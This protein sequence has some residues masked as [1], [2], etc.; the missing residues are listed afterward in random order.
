M[1]MSSV[2]D[3]FAKN[4]NLKVNGALSVENS[5]FKGVPSGYGLF[6]DLASINYDPNDVTIELLRIPR[7]A[8]FSLDTLLELIKDETQYSSKENMEKLH[9]TVRAVFSQFL[10][11]DGLKSLLSETTVLVF[12]FTLLTLVKE[13][14]EL[15][16]TLR[17]YLEDV[18]LQVKVDNAPMFCEQAAELYGQ[19]SM[20]V[21]L[22]DVLD[23][24]EDFFKNKV[25]CSRSVLPLLRQVYAAIS[26]RSL[27]IPDEVA[28]NSDDFVVNTTLVPLLDFANHSNDLKNAHFD[29]DRQTRDVLLLLDVD[30]IPA[31]A[32]KFEIFISYSPVED[33]ISFIHY[34]GFVPSSADKCQFI[35]LSFDRGYLREQE[36]MPAVNLR[37]FYKWM[38]INPVVQ[39]INFQNCWHINDSTEQFAYLLLAFMHSPDSESSSCWAYDPTCYRTFWYFQEHSSKR[40]EDYISINDYKSRIA[41]LENDDSD[42]IDLPQLAWSMSFQGD[43]LSTHRGRFPKD[44][45]LQL[46]PFDNE[47]TFS[48]A[49][50]LFAKFFLGYIE[51]RLDKLENSEPHLTSPPLKQLVRLEKS[52]LLQLLHEPHLYYWSDRQVDCESYD[53]T[54]RPLLDR[55]HRDADR[56]ASKDV[57]SLENLSLEDY[58]PEDFTDFLQDELKLYANLV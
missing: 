23:L 8:T 1:S 37:L 3:W 4:A 40:K 21:A 12:Y 44:E 9:A 57:L 19:Y 55:G 10:E 17:F 46:A 26:S 20:F 54:L 16:K 41:S 31:N 36:P 42:L 51:W 7:L 25:S 24:L 22:K 52:V 39:L 33:L 28:E 48:N 30:R 45:A 6:V 14:Y 58:H 47:R 34:Y 5:F 35:S 2:V 53:C 49:I 27:E 32:T 50:D 43:G 15:P 11:L 18:L 38:Q 13:E 56:N 29:I